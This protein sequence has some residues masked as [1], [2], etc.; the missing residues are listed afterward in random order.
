MQDDTQSW[1][2]L[3]HVLGGALETHKCNYY[4][5]QWDFKG[6]SIPELNKTVQMEMQL[7][8]S[9][10]TQVTLHNDFIKEAHKTL[11]T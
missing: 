4:A 11:W 8:A 2:D 9:N 7:E 5:M 6:N 1:G 3:L 10:G